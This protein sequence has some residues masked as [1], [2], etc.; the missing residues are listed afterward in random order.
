[1]PFDGGIIDTSPDR[2]VLSLSYIDTNGQPRT[3]SYEMPLDVTDAEMNAF[4][5][6]M[7]AAT[8]ASLWGVQKSTIFAP[9][10]PSKANAV[11]AVDDSVKDNIVILYKNNAN[12]SVDLFIPAPLEAELIAGTVNPDPANALVIAVMAAADAI[13][14]S[15]NAISLRYTERRKKN[16]ATKL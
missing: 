9:S 12:L 11:A 10:P 2:I 13:W 1:M 14:T 16:R 15:Y 6:A 5:V 4:A 3:D 7:G 8:N